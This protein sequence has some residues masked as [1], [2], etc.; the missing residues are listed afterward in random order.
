MEFD[1]TKRRWAN[2]T[3][4]AYYLGVSLTTLARWK[5]DPAVAFPAPRVVGKSNEL[6]D[7]DK[8]DA[9]MESRESQR[10]DRQ[11]KSEDRVA[12]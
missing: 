1:R 8:V 12:A 9:W 3:Q 5:R 10:V 7:L 4:A 6:N 11:I 2:N